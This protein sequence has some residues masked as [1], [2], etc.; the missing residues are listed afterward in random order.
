MRNRFL[1]KKS[2]YYNS[3]DEL[4]EKLSIKLS[5]REEEEPNEKY[6]IKKQCQVCKNH[7]FKYICPKCKVLYCSLNCYTSHNNKCTE[8][9]YKSNV[10]EELKGVVNQFAFAVNY[11]YYLCEKSDYYTDLI[12][13][14]KVGISGIP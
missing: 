3:V 13:K 4:M 2:E 1:K 12:I 7:D 8:E 9:F 11:N 5:N 14:E 10:I 6:A